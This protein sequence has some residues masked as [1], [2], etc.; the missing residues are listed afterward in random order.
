MPLKARI[1]CYISG[2]TGRKQDSVNIK[3]VEVPHPARNSRKA[4]TKKIIGSL[5]LKD[6]RILS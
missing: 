3:M 1:S 2:V 5:R 4:F 6:S